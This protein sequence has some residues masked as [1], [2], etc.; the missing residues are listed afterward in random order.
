MLRLC[1]VKQSHISNK[2]VPQNKNLCHSLNSAANTTIKKKITQKKNCGGGI[3]YSMVA[4]V[5][6]LTDLSIFISVFIQ[7]LTEI[8]VLAGE[9][10]EKTW[11]ARV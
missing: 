6:L 9:N 11:D 8:Q 1:Q 10:V 4:V 7:F 5:L 3:I 2:K